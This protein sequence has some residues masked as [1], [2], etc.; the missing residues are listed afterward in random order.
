MHW[1]PNPSSNKAFTA[2][3]IA[4]GTL[5]TSCGEQSAKEL[6][7]VRESKG[8]NGKFTY[9]S[10]LL[11]WEMDI[12]QYW[13]IIAPEHPDTVPGT[14][15]AILVDRNG[16]SGIEAKTDLLAF[17]LNAQNFFVASIEPYNAATDGELETAITNIGFALEDYYNQQGVGYEHK[18]SRTAINGLEFLTH[19]FRFAAEEGMEPVVQI[20][21]YRQFGP[22]VLGI[23]VNYD[24][25]E[26]RV[27]MLSALKAA[28]FG[29][30]GTN[31]PT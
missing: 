25:H 7:E 4:L 12:P 9:R 17:Q 16:L 31:Q 5:L 23:L 10:E 19:T 22:A 26:A 13:E 21:Y 15:R 29:N 6:P 1:L 18:A 24:K 8:F 20:T 3:F 2:L 30:R 11:S 14:T 28:T 27:A